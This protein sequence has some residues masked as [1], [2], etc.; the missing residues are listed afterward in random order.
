MSDLYSEWIVNRKKPSWAFAAKV[1]L[2]CLTVICGLLTMTGIFWFMLIPTVALG[3]LTYRLSLNWDMEYEY[4][5]VKGELDIDK[6]MAKSKRKRCAVL[7]MDQTEIVAPEG[8]HQLDNFKNTPCK[9]M[10]FSS[11]I[12]ENKKYVMYTSYHNEMVKIIFEPSERML[13]DMWNTAPR[14]VVK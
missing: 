1:E 3:Y 13:D 6:I 11:H 5:F 14:K 2:I 7:N 8:A 10:D 12:P 9:T 4:T